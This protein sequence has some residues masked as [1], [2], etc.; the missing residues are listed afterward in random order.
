MTEL[1][2]VLKLF[3]SVFLCRTTHGS[4]SGVE[5]LDACLRDERN[6]FEVTSFSG[7]RY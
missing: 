7:D 1:Q 3:T 6:A 5:A 4:S 2:V